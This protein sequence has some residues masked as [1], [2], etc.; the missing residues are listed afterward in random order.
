MFDA[1]TNDD[2]EAM[3]EAGQA[4]CDSHIA[5]AKSGDNIV[6]ELLK[7]YETF[8]EWNHYPE[9]DV[10]D[11]KTHAQYYYHAHPGEQRRDEHGHFHTFLRPLGM[12]SG[13]RPAPLLDFTPPDGANDA[14]SHIVAIS[15]DRSGMPVRLFTTNRWVTGEV[16]YEA[17]DVARFI[18]RFAI[19]LAP[20]RRP[21]DRWVGYMLAL[22]RPQIAGLLQARDAKVAAWQQAHP[23]RNAYEDR[24][25]EVTSMAEIDVEAQF[26]AVRS[27]LERRRSAPKS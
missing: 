22:F 1:L 23:D 20:P 10:Q 21:V 17:V 15:M 2:L 14:L 19:D 13:I 6:G 9:G 26:T 18:G 24:E 27:E 3:A 16:W 12:P 8:Y 11:P 4:I 5:L 7:P 25:L